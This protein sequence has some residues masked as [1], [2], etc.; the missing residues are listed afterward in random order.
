MLATL[1]AVA[2]VSAAAAPSATLAGTR[3]AAFRAAVIEPLL[4]SAG[5]KAGR[6]RR[7]LDLNAGDGMCGIKDEMTWECGISC[8]DFGK[9][10]DKLEAV[11]KESDVFNMPVCCRLLPPPL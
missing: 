3:N 5:N 10:L 9:E 4:S 7:L 1:C 11:A 2:A 6:L 8:A